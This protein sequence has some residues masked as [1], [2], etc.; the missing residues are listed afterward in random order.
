MVKAKRTVRSFFYFICGKIEKGDNMYQ[1]YGKLSTKYY[2][3]SKPIGFE[4]MGDI[5]F[6]K[7]KLK[8]IQGPILEAG[9]GTGR[10]MIPLLE[11]GFQVEGIDSSKAMLA[12]CQKA[13]DERK[14]APKLEQKDLLHLQANNYYEAIIMPTGSFMLLEEAAQVLKRFYQA[15][16]KG[17][18]LIF[19]LEPFR[20][21]DLGAQNTSVLAISE[22]EGI[23]LTSTHLAHDPINQF[24]Q[25]LLKYEYFVDGEFNAS[26]LQNFKLYY[27]GLREITMM[28]EAVGFTSIEVIADYDEEKALNHE[29]DLLT[30]IAKKGTF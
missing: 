17:G 3:Y 7:N 21:F 5:S 8:G 19:D 16:Q 12:V 11:S 10:M 2:Q 30:L 4:I 6:Y 13:C 27:Y 26:E 15:L 14:K 9:V 23:V 20:T 22:T 25:T 18:R 29:T 24:T 1:S 28:L